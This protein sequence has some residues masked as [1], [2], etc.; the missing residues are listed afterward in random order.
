MTLDRVTDL[1]TEDV[2]TLVEE[3]SWTDADEEDSVAV[4]AA[5][6]YRV[7]YL[8]TDHFNGEPVPL[9]PLLELGARANICPNVGDPLGQESL[10]KLKLY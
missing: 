5:F 7:E 1:D 6:Q 3:D 10:V 2:D 8:L 9:V 4:I